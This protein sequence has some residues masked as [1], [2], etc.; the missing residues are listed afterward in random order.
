MLRSPQSYV[1]CRVGLELRFKARQ[2]FDFLFEDNV[3]RAQRSEVSMQN[4]GFSAGDGHH[5]GFT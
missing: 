4:P 3:G 5:L 1:Y 2:V